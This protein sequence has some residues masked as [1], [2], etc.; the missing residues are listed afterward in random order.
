MR[1]HLR[2]QPASLA[3]ATAITAARLRAAVRGAVLAVFLLSAPLVLAACPGPSTGPGTNTPGPN[4][5]GTNTPGTQPAANVISG[6]VTDT[7][8]NPLPNAEIIVFG[9]T[10]GSDQQRYTT[11]TDSNGA[12]SV[13]VAAGQYYTYAF[14][15]VTYENTAWSL[16][17]D[18]VDGVNDMQNPANGLTKDFRWKLDGLQP[19]Q[20]AYDPHNFYGVPLHLNFAGL[21]LPPDGATFTFTLTPNGPLIDGSTGQT[22]TFQRSAQAMRTDPGS[23]SLDDTD[24]L[25]DIPIGDY[26]ITGQVTLA[27]GSTQSLT[28]DN[29]TSSEDLQWYYGSNAAIHTIKEASV[30]VG[31]AGQ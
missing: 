6:T 28:F 16:P 27:D 23:V 1:G 13:Q 20:P 31:I 24:N 12:Y 7:Q 15:N 26:T 19:Q 11:T 30:T 14:A 29:G 25:Y 17:L 21:N 5:P 4:G 2:R 8:G 22:L 18:P 10:N 3:L 9:T